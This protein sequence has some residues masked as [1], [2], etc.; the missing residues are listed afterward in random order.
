MKPLSNR[1]EL[2]HPAVGTA[3]TC[4]DFESESRATAPVTGK[5]RTTRWIEVSGSATDSAI[6]PRYQ[7][8]G[9]INWGSTCVVRLVRDVALR[10]KVAMK[11]LKPECGGDPSC[12]EQLIA[13]AQVTSQMDH[14]NIIPV[15]DVGLDVRHGPYFTMKAVQGKSLQ[16]WLSD[17]HHPVGSARRLS[18]GLPMFGKVCNAIAFAHLSGVIHRDLKPGNIMLGTCG[19]VYVV[20][21]GLARLLC[22][23]S[24]SKFPHERPLRPYPIGTLAYMSPEAARGED[25]ACDERSDIFGLGAVLYEIVTGA[26]PYAP[27]PRGTPLWERARS[28]RYTPIEQIVGVDAVPSGLGGILRKAMAERREH[29][30]QTARELKMDVKRFCKSSGYPLH[31]V[32][33]QPKEC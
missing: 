9:I 27:G 14:P 32:Q 30:Y 20:D 5:W 6:E 16:E 29:R 24:K 23:T 7:D 21:W 17:R 1:K 25:S 18:A 28:G 22:R 8:L 19:E 12:V 31:S 2:R 11:A 10:R 3:S 13:E 26:K 15:Y 4:P 33:M